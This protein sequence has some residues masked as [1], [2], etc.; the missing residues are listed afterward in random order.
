MRLYLQDD[1]FLFHLWIFLSHFPKNI[2]NYLLIS[3]LGVSG[4]DRVSVSVMEGDSVILHTGVQTNQQ[5]KIKWYFQVTCIARI[6]G[7]LSKT[8]TDVQCNEGTERFRGR[9]KLDHQ[10]GS[11]TIMNINTTHSGEYTLEVIRGNNKETIFTVF[12][13]TYEIYVKAGENVTLDPAVLK[14]PIHLMTWHFNNI[15]IAEITEDQSKISTDDQ[16]NNRFRGRLEVNQT[17]SLT[18]TNTRSEDSGVYKLQTNSSR[19]SIVRSFR[20]TI[21][22]HIIFKLIVIVFMV[23]T[24]IQ[25]PRL[26]RLCIAHRERA[27][28][29]L[30]NGRHHQVPCSRTP[31]TLE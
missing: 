23:S 20:V 12:L 10:T 13:F 3:F 4:A 18:I 9:L 16:V 30:F 29:C 1:T 14:N 2:Y 15:S 6:N 28:K 24:I 7:D 5:E 31:S 19:F 22:E 17:G 26:Q 8:C 27:C 25:Y 21:T 11:L